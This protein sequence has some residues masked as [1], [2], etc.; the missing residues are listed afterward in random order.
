LL[1]GN[2]LGS[3]GVSIFA[4]GTPAVPTTNAL[5]LGAAGAVSLTSAGTGSITI[6]STGTG[7]VD[8]TSGD[9]ID[10]VAADFINITST[11]QVQ[12]TSGGGLDIIL[13]SNGDIQLTASANCFVNG[14]VTCRKEGGGFA[15]DISAVTARVTADISVTDGTTFSLPVINVVKG[16]YEFKAMLFYDCAGANAEFDLIIDPTTGNVLGSVVDSSALGSGSLSTKVDIFPAA[17]SK[18]FT[19]GQSTSS[20]DGSHWVEGEVEFTSDTAVTC[21]AQNIGI[22]PGLLKKGSYFRFFMI[23]KT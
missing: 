21:K 10:V 20:T 19:N 16:V 1:I 9:S 11:S 8:I 4:G 2:A 5:R 13:N 3:G 18:T 15:L 6:T 23:Q 12:L 17:A 22:D 14:V 7:S